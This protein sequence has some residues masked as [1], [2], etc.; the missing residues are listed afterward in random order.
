MGSALARAQEG[1]VAES[2]IAARTLGYAGIEAYQNGDYLLADEKLGRAYRV[3][4]VP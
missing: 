1:T 2:V 4:P 3:L